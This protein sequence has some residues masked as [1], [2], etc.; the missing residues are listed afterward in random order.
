MLLRIIGKVLYRLFAEARWVV[1]QFLEAFLHPLS[2]SY[3]DTRTG[4]VTGRCP[5]FGR[6]RTIEIRETRQGGSNW[7]FAI[8]VGMILAGAILKAWT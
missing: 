4:K 2:V 3:F 8:A 5:A 1:N 7:P 6:N